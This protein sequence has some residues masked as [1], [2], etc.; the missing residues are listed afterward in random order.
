MLVEVVNEVGY[1]EEEVMDKLFK[2][3]ENFLDFLWMN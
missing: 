1:I 2:W 3:C